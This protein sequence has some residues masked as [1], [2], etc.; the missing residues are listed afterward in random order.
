MKYVELGIFLTDDL[1]IKAVVIDQN[2]TGL[3]SNSELIEKVCITLL[4]SLSLNKEDVQLQ[5]LLNELN[6]KS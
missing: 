2:E 6:I 3:P 1:G 5:D 4:K